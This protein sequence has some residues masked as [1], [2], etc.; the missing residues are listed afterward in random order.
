MIDVSAYVASLL[1]VEVHRNGFLILIA[2]IAV[3]SVKA[4]QIWIISL[5][6]LTHVV[7]VANLL[8]VD[9]A[10]ILA[11]R[12]IIS[13]V[14][15]LIPV[16]IHIIEAFKT[17]I[18]TMV[19]VACI[20]EVALHGGSNIVGAVIREVSIYTIK[21][22][23]T[24]GVSITYRIGTGNSCI[25]IYVNDDIL[26]LLMPCS[27]GIV[28]AII[29]WIAAVS[30]NAVVIKVSSVWGFIITYPVGR[31]IVESI[32]IWVGIVFNKVFIGKVVSVST[33]ILDECT[34]SGEVSIAISGFDIIFVIYPEPVG[35]H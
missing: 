30:L 25:A 13:V 34:I 14:S 5:C 15:E 10:V 27:F 2:P 8:T 28:V 19:H 20:S 16:A 3:K 6:K 9:R 33:G 22:G 17:L 35:N 11:F 1:A 29:V 24:V 18:F 12:I 26:A 4:I 31:R 21:M 32:Y 23:I 7:V